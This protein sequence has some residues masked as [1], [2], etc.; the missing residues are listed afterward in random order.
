MHFY[1]TATS[2]TRRIL[3]V[4]LPEIG[5]RRTERQALEPILGAHQMPPNWRFHTHLLPRD[6][7]IFASETG[8]NRRTG[9]SEDRSASRSASRS[10]EGKAKYL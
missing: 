8:M 7:D 4:D 10:A 6:Y 2:I 1:A 3:R 9:F 5:R